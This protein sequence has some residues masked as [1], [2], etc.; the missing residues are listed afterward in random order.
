MLLP[1][2]HISFRESI[3]GF[4]TTILSFLDRPLTIEQIWKT[5]QRENPNNNAIHGFDILVLTLDVLF[6]IDVIS[7]SESGE[8]ARSNRGEKKKCA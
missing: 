5:Y 8:I 3:I 6:A 1:D 2:K 4:G 7:I